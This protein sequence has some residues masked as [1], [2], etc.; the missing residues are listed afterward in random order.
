MFIYHFALTETLRT[1]EVRYRSILADSL[2][3][4]LNQLRAEFPWANVLG[5]DVTHKEM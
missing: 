5:W 4:A 3:E 1:S 2:E